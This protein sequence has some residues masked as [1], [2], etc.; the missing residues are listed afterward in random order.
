MRIGRKWKPC[1]RDALSTYKPV[2]DGLGLV[3]QVCVT[4][5]RKNVVRRLRKVKGW[6]E[7]K[8]RLRGLL[9]ELSDDGGKQ[10]MMM[11]REA[12][13]KSDLRRLAAD[14]MREMAQ[15]AVLQAIRGV[16]DTKQ[17]NGASD[18][19]EQGKI[20]DNARIQEYGGSEYSHPAGLMDLR[21]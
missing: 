11:E 1:N 21:D 18:R 19:Q 4:H 3:R 15:P 9:D 8:S 20:Q 10:L 5:A 7:W 2:V 14:F 12:R 16:C 6:Q 13:D 17:C